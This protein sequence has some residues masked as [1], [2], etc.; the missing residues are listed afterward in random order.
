MLN[1]KYWLNT[2]SK[3]KPDTLVR[4]QRTS[5]A[6]KI[7]RLNRLRECLGG[8]HSFVLAKRHSLRLYLKKNKALFM[9]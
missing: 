6:E 4:E 5:F 9:I 1:E 3:K 8:R 2:P 7:T